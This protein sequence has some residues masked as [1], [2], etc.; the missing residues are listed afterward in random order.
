MKALVFSPS[1]SFLKTTPSSTVGKET[2]GR[3][4]CASVSSGSLTLMPKFLATPGARLNIEE[5]A[6]IQR[7]C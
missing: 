2:G 5:T 1:P 3:V 6:T 7:S 4:L